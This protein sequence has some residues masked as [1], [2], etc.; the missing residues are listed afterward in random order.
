MIRILQLNRVRKFIGSSRLD[1]QLFFSSL[2]QGPTEAMGTQVRIK[3]FQARFKEAVPNVAMPAITLATAN[4]KMITGYRIGEAMKKFQ[5]HQSDSGSAPVQIAVLTEKI[6]NLAR[7][8]TAHR[9]DNSNK[10]G[11]EMMISQRK[12]MLKYLKR[13]DIESF[14][15]VVRALNLEKEASQIR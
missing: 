11:F 7:H 3:Q 8:V 4:Q 10:R 13:Y 1:S 14:R 12:R 5:L 15:R 2:G 9:K 6:K